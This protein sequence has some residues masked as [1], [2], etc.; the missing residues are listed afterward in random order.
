M[1]EQVTIPAGVNPAA[2]GGNGADV[3]HYGTRANG[4]SAAPGSPGG[5]GG[6]PA[7]PPAAAQRPGFDAGASAGDAEFAAFKAW[8][9]QQ[10]KGAPPAATTTTPEAKPT[11][12]TPQAPTLFG[13]VNGPQAA[14]EATKQAA[15]SDPVIALTFENMSTLAP[16]L[17]VVRALGNAIDRAD[18][19]LIDTA[20][21][22]E[23]GGDKAERLIALATNMVN[24]VT[25]S[26]DNMVSEIEAKAGGQA[27]WNANTAAF[28][29]SAPAYLKAYVKE[30]LNSANP[31]KIRQGVD[32]VLEFAKT[33]GAL[34]RNPTGHVAAGGGVPNG[35]I[36]LSKEGYQAE[37]LKLNKFDRGYNDAARELDARRAIGKKMGL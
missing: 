23:V 34:P 24:H 31:A 8:Q 15:A 27:A 6:I 18:L 17:N 9:A 28:N 35:V 32:A 2:A 13:D 21:L 25:T 10:G 1:A 5:D 7:V 33:S 20:Y 37:R 3:T 12:Q 36:G 16:G 22:R 29:T 11:P 4:G 26:V 19:S 14:M 30:A